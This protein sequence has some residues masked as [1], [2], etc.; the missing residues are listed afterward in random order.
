[1]TATTPLSATAAL[2]GGGQ[3][4]LIGF[5]T[6]ELSGGGAREAVGWALEAGYRHLD[7]ATMYRNEA[8][9]GRAVRESGVPRTDVF[10]TTKLPQDRARQARAT[11]EASLAALDTDHVDLWLIHWPPGRG[12]GVA[13]WRDLIAAR[14]EGLA[15]AIGVSNYSLDQIDELRAE[16]GVTPAVN[17]IRWGPALFDREVSDGHRERGVL[18]E[19]YSPFKSGRLDHPVLAEIAARHGTGPAQVVV[20]WHLQ[21]GVVVI[22]KSARRDRIVGNVDVG[23]FALS[24][25]EMAAIDALGAQH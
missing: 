18:L 7:T 9:V 2:T 15:T 19:G 12:A 6:W 23:G 1:M 17:Q 5:G 11:L 16:T 20:R 25:D 8:E 24:D 10:L 14:D 3:I 13:T 22:P 21:H 4:P